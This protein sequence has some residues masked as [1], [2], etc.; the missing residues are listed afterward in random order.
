[1]GTD[2]GR[3]PRTLPQ[4]SLRQSLDTVQCLVGRATAMGQAL[5]HGDREA[6]VLD[7]QA[8]LKEVTQTT[9]AQAMPFLSALDEHCDLQKRAV[10]VSQRLV[11]LDTRFGITAAAAPSLKLAAY[12]LTTLQAADR[13]VTGGRLVGTVGAAYGAG[14]EAIDFVR[15]T[16]GDCTAPMTSVT[17][18]PTTEEVA[19]TTPASPPTVEMG[20]ELGTEAEAAAAAPE[21]PFPSLPLNPL[22]GPD[23]LTVTQ[24]SAASSAEAVRLMEREAYSRAAFLVAIHRHGRM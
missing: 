5:A 10:A 15:Q 11:D 1:M 24:P 20:P 18:T 19:V 22:A 17:P 21:A 16:A 6:V 12:V 7:A 9:I 23:V 14:R 4:L 8:A 2:T 13:A 3:S